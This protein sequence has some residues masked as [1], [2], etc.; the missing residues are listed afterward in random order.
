MTV[1]SNEGKLWI[2][3]KST[4]LNVPN[5]VMASN[6]FFFPFLNV[7]IV[8][9]FV[10]TLKLMAVRNR[11]FVVL[12]RLKINFNST[13]WANKTKKKMDTNLSWLFQFSAFEWP[14]D[15]RHTRVIKR[16]KKN[17]V[18]LRF[19]TFV[20]KGFEDKNWLG[21]TPCWREIPRV[22]RKQ[23]R[24]KIT[25]GKSKV[26]SDRRPKRGEFESAR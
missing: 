17:K 15:H 24:C 11:M 6:F 26:N 7:E 2:E 19:K 18:C 10:Y 1:T 23:C 16:R 5:A 21:R 20:K 4:K 22:K 9:L 3:M 12:H 8:K 13:S 14:P 25:S